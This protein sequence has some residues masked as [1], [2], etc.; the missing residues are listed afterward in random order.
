MKAERG[1]MAC[2]QQV[3]STRAERPAQGGKETGQEVRLPVK[4]QD[5]YPI[6]LK[7]SIFTWDVSLLR[8]KHD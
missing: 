7:Y 4:F 2:Y 1:A 6:I 5:E 8:K 3:T